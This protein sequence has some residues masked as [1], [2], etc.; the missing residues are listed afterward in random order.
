MFLSSRCLSQPRQLGTPCSLLQATITATR[1]GDTDFRIE[2]A[3][4]D[5]GKLLAFDVAIALHA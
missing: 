3:G 1:L 5:G 4:A 2:M